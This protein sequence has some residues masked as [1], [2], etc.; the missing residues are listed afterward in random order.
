MKCWLSNIVFVFAIT[1]Q[2]WVSEACPI[3]YLVNILNEKVSSPIREKLRV[4]Q[5][6]KHW[7]ESKRLYESGSDLEIIK[8]D[9]RYFEFDSDESNNLTPISSLIPRNLNIGDELKVRLSILDQPITIQVKEIKHSGIIV[10]SVDAA[11]ILSKYPGAHLRSPTYVSW[12]NGNDIR[13]EEIP[14][15]SGQIDLELVPNGDGYLIVNMPRRGQNPSQVFDMVPDD[16]GF[17]Q[18]TFEK[19]SL[20]V[21]R[22]KTRQGDEVYLSQDGKGG[23]IR[24][25]SAFESEYYP[26]HDSTYTNLSNLWLASLQAR[27]LRLRRANP[28]AIYEGLMNKGPIKYEQVGQYIRP[29]RRYPK[30]KV[31]IKIH[32]TVWPEYFSEF[33]KLLIPKLHDK[34]IEFKLINDIETAEMIY[35]EAFREAAY[36]SFQ[37]GK[38]LVVYPES[39]VHALELGVLLDDWLME[40][41]VRGG[42]PI[43]GDRIVP[44]TRS[45]SLYYRFD[46]SERGYFHVNDWIKDLFANP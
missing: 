5:L 6:K 19:M 18:A 34:W 3:N 35:T 37:T 39:N 11:A 38:F 44:N 27:F 36:L 40:I 26:I 4:A 32:V 30:S 33:A 31:D 22:G 14:I 2:P 21:I 42:P 43:V 7:A 25:K 13:S 41:P 9:K 16:S 15:K 45:G 8:H 24:L 20:G 12:F 46:S 29:K 23:F 10:A 17:T 28:Y 1:L